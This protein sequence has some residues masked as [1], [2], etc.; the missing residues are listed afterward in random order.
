MTCNIARLTQYHDSPP[1]YTARHQPDPDS[2]S[3][4][5]AAPSYISAAPSYHSAAP[6][7]PTTT[8]TATTTTLASPP[9]STTAITAT[10]TS[11][12]RLPNPTYAP[13]FAPAHLRRG[14]TNLG[15]LSAHSYSI[16]S[17]SSV[18][19]SHQSRHYHRVANRRATLASAETERAALAAAI[20]TPRAQPPPNSSEDILEED[21]YLVGSEAAARAKR[22][23]L[24]GM[25]RGEEA[26]RQEDKAWDFMLKQMADWEERERSWK[27]FR[28][29]LER[30]G[31]LRRRL[32]LVGRVSL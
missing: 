18:G 7:Q 8:T 12:T 17:W 25:R 23:R 11:P 26:L 16:P 1:V 10:A 2:T 29:E 5:S 4:R 28:R 19:S 30:P 14:S 6:A 13:G 32:G 27:K 22:E 31:L 24:Q 9:T 21:P 15:E 20:T 3:I